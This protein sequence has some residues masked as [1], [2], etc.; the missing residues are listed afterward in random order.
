MQEG[1]SLQVKQLRDD[2]ILRKQATGDSAGFDLFSPVAVSVPA[3]SGVKIPLHISMAIPVGHY[4]RIAS[5]S[6]F[7][8]KR[9]HVASGVIDRGYRG[10]VTVL[11]ENSGDQ[12]FT[13][14][15]GDRIAQLILEKHSTREAP[16]TMSD[17]NDLSAGARDSLNLVFFVSSITALACRLFSDNRIIISPVY[18]TSGLC[19][20]EATDSVLCQVSQDLLGAG[21]TREASQLDGLYADQWGHRHEA[22]P[23][24]FLWLAAGMLVALIIVIL[25]FCHA[26]ILSYD[27]IKKFLDV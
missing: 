23:Q 20:T 8:A 25:K 1:S 13:I 19:C 26:M 14:Q 16:I 12:P 15:K 5:R 11:L 22:R 4:G 7:S 2:V 21:G 9:V 27:R 18:P 24:I 17:R 6:S 10:D 3:Q